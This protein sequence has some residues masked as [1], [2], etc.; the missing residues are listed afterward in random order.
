MG[1]VRCFNDDGTE[2]HGFYGNDHDDS[3]VRAW[4][5]Q[6]WLESAEEESNG[7][8]DDFYSLTETENLQVELDAIEA[9]EAKRWLSLTREEK[10]KELEEEEKINI[11]N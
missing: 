10:I 9:E 1:Y 3:D 5:Q 6:A 8:D 4:K 7:S 2:C 11:T